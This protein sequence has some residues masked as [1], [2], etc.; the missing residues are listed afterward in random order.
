MFVNS[1]LAP[2]LG[3][4]R[5]LTYLSGIVDKYIHSYQIPCYRNHCDGRPETDNV[6]AGLEID[7]R[8]DLGKP[9]IRRLD[10]RPYR[11]PRAVY[12]RYYPL[13]AQHASIANTYQWRRA[14]QSGV[15]V[16]R[17]SELRGRICDSGT[18]VVGS[19]NQGIRSSGHWRR[20][21]TPWVQGF[22]V[23]RTRAR[24]PSEKAE[25]RCECVGEKF[26]PH[27]LK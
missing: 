22:G 15:S 8:R 25:T 24:A 14:R 27:G 7:E 18:F 19:I 1:R 2:V 20:A 5:S 9:Y 26:N 10:N 13:R 16:C 4:G 17:A 23:V 12:K 6:A 3:P 21:A 11:T